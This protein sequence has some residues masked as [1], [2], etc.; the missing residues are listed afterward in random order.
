MTLDRRSVLAKGLTT[1][2]LGAMASG[3]TSGRAGAQTPPPVSTKG[4]PPG[5]PQPSETLDLWPG[6][7]PGLP[8]PAPV[9]QV[10]ER[11]T[12]PLVNDRAVYGITRPR[13]VVFRPDR[14]NG[15]AVLIAPGGGYR[16]VVV[17]KEGYEMGRWLAA[18]G[19][20]AFVLFYR[21]PGEGWAGGP[22]T[23]LADAQRAMR[24]IRHRAR[25]FAI[26]PERV[27]AMG[28]SA[29]GHV[30]ADLAARWAAPVY[31]P[32]DAADRLSAK[33]HCAAPLYPVVSMDPAIAHPGSR[34]KLLGPSPTAQA[35][36]AHSPDRQ[37][38]AAA[39]PHFLLHAEDDDVVP[40]DNTLRL[41]AAL[42]AARVPVELHLF[43]HGGHGF[44]LRKT[45]GKPVEAWPDLWRAWVRTMGLG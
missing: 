5:L 2:M 35:E 10:D 8:S 14:P 27:A 24:L 9:E 17:D 19:F 21:L 40:V 22:D 29:G 33:P 7:A 25:D 26:D 6:G 16:W 44:G 39:P 23:P 38:T 37:I 41:H 32:V 1:T 11:S 20:T 36:A 18:R 45:V 13:L 28:F 4:L 42:R 3:A 12:D 43:T 30:C 15:A 34:A 31:A